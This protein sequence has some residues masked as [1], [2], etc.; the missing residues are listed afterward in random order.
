MFGCGSNT[1]KSLESQLM[2]IRTGEGKSM[3]LGAAAVILSLLGFRVRT[4]CYSDYLSKRDFKLFEELFDRFGLK[5]FIRYS[6]ITTFAEDSTATKGDIRSLTESLLRGSL[7]KPMNPTKKALPGLMPPDTAD[8]SSNQLND[9]D[10]SSS[11]SGNNTSNPNTGCEGLIDSSSDVSI[12]STTSSCM[13]VAMDTAGSPQYAAQDEVST[14]SAENEIAARIKN[15]HSPNKN[16]SQV[17]QQ[18]TRQPDDTF[19]TTNALSSNCNHTPV[20]ITDSNQNERKEVLLVDEVDVFFGSEFYGQT[21][22][23]VVEFREPEIGEIIKRIWNAF[24]QGGRRL[25]L[26]DIQSMPEYSRLLGKLPSYLLD[27]EISLMLDQVKRVNDVPYFIDPDTDR[28][29]Y[30]VMDYISYDVTYGYATIFAYLKE[31]DNLSRKETLANAL[32]MPISC[33]QFSYAKI[34]PYRIIGVSGTLQAL[35]DY[36]KGVLAQ[37]GLKRSIF[38]PSVY[39]ASNFAFDKAGDGIYFECN[40]SD[41]NHRLLSEITSVIKSKRSVVVFFRDRSKLD[42]FVS[43]PTYRQLGRHKKLLTEDTN[44]LDKEYIIKK[45]ATAGQITLCTSVFGRG[46]DFFCKDEAVEKNGGVHIIQTFL[47]EEITEEIQIQGRTARQGKQGTYQLILLESDLVTEFGVSPGEQMKVPK[48]NWYDWLCTIRNKHHDKQCKIMETNLLRASDV[49][50]ATHKY[51]DSLLKCDIASALNDF[52][53]LYQTIKKPPY[54]ALLNLDLAFAIDV[55][56]S[57]MP[58]TKCIAT[59]IQG[60]IDGQNSIIEKLKAK[61][62]EI[63]FKMR[64]GCLGFRDI[65]DKNDQFKD[66]CFDGGCHFTEDKANV[67]AFINGVLDNASGGFDLAEDHLGALHR[68]TTDWNHVNDWTAEIKCVLLFTDSPAHGFVP[69]SFSAV[70]NLDNY[71][72]RHPNGL[73]VDHVVASLVKNKIDLFFCSFNPAATDRVEDELS[74]AL[75]DH[76]DSANDSGIIQIPMVPKSNTQPSLLSGCERH[77]IFVLDESGSM[78]GNWSGVVRAYNEYIAKRKQSQCDGDLVSVVQFDGSARV[79]V[80]PTALCSAP[81]SL[82]YHGGG[83]CFHPAAISACQLA[84]QTASSHTTTIVFMSDGQ[85]GDAAAAAQEFS[86]LN[87]DILLQ[88]EKDL[89]LHVIAFGTRASYS[90]L[91]L[92]AGASKI[93]KV[94]S[95]SNTGDLAKVFVGIAANTN[96]STMLESEITKRISEAVSDKLSLEYFG[97]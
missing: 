65:D 16:T 58:F 90:Q 36:E 91:Q 75:K 87:N 57:M 63:D 51:F 46:T 33:G 47:S 23:Q 73:G 1:N 12:D 80:Q 52:Q 60:L 56:G 88:T 71:S 21:Y 76:P 11:S 24:D 8:S 64:F 53:S 45:A 66:S 77:I 27:N 4:V 37:Y 43:S 26:N 97:S 39:G 70:S 44:S 89:E 83:T 13:D 67:T 61:F 31:A 2:Q 29:G 48:R 79:T 6:K 15:H 96:V 20:S 3:I 49:D 81:T 9:I 14:T 92:I 50:S 85:A 40:E 10:I 69:T 17:Q 34:S 28:I 72:V 18:L 22:N 74:Q 55:T 5:K 68:C 19:S 38:V 41:Y 54:P 95:S 32:V 86:T 59:T 42:A 62:P 78:G 35:G 84:R 93:G 82:P 30:K 25:K 7:T 94:H